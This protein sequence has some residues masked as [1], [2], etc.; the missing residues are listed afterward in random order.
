ME[1]SPSSLM[2]GVGLL[3]SF[4]YLFV[5]IKDSP[6][7]DSDPFIQKLPLILKLLGV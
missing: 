6:N 2:L 1:L 4:N 5:L 7:I 3:F